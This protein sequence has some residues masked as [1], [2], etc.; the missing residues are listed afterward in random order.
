M[1]HVT[2][3]P[4]RRLV[5]VGG[6]LALGA[7]GAQWWQGQAVQRVLAEG[8]VTNKVDPA[9][10]QHAKALSQAF[11]GAADAVLPT[12][13]TIETRSKPRA[14]ANPRG[15]AVPRGQNPFKGT[16][17][18]DFFNDEEMPFGGNPFGGG[19]GGGTQPRGG[20]T[21]S[22]V[23]IDPSGIILTNNHVVEGADEVIVRFSDE[24]ELKADE[25]KTDPQTDLAVI[26]LKGAGTL[27][28]ARLGDSTKLDIG[29]WV[30]A[31]G[32]PFGL[33][34]TVSAG[35]ISGKGRELGSGQRAR[36][37]QTDA[38][39]NPGNSGGPLV[40]LDGEVIGINTAIASRSG[41]FQGIGFAIPSDLAKW[42][43]KQLI[44]GG[45]VRRAYLG[46]AIEQVNG[47][48]AEQFGVRQNQGVLVSEVFKDSPAE[49]A[50]FKVGDVI[51]KFAGSGVRNP[52]DLQ[53]VVE[54][55][56]F[57]SKQPVE[58]VRDGKP[59]VLEVVVKPLP[60]DFGS[61][62]RS[63]VQRGDKEDDAT[64]GHFDKQIGVEVSNLTT[65]EAEQLGF[66][67]HKGV[68][69]TDVEEGSAAATAGLRA[70]LLI[71]RVGKQS[72]ENVEQF[73]EAM[74]TVNVKEGVLLL[75]RTESGQRFVVIRSNK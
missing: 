73:R 47:T 49:V 16:P 13:V 27:P 43:V 34:S 51:V 32:A 59:Q 11:R 5:L 45:E 14:A 42:V 63:R 60:E 36:F 1:S 48:L 18:E 71:T 24:R 15:R 56:P 57:E 9:I 64:R 17:F 20:G 74:K 7:V 12:V 70:G 6:L 4:V 72:V 66:A 38:A 31:V 2:W 46:V 55:C 54:K 23:I 65:R 53:E 10:S 52:R 39:I 22:G 28:F 26:R 58:V 50:G 25:I 62:A 29:D 68:V 37:L 61:Q 21:G 8:P 67:N 41:G 75:V 69:I 30:I 40:N 19:G 44:E 33:D 3:Q 35:I